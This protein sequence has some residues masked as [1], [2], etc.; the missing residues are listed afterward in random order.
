MSGRKINPVHDWTEEEHDFIVKNLPG[1]TF[2]QMAELV[3]ER[4]G[5]SCHGW[6]V[7]S[8]SIST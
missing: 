5:W 3:S 6:N 1:K 8:H 7:Y 2:S 4:F